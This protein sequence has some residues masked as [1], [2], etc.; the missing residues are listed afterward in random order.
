[1]LCSDLWLNAEFWESMQLYPRRKL[2]QLFLRHSSLQL[3]AMPNE[4]KHFLLFA[5]EFRDAYFGIVRTENER[6]EQNNLEAI[7]SNIAQGENIWMG[8]GC[9]TPC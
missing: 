3:G 9:F 1:M 7:Y 5:V 6:A 2:T 4:G 8:S